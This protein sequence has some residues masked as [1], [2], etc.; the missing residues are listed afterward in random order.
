MHPN[1]LHNF[2]TLCNNVS[3]AILK[4]GA[5]IKWQAREIY[6]TSARECPAGLS[7][8]LATILALQT[9]LY[10]ISRKKIQGLI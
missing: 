10:Q 2:F 3:V 7:R 6:P 9:K 5:G 1:T 4:R 8:A